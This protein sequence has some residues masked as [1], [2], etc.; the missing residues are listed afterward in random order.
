MLS[1]ASAISRVSR[2]PVVLVLHAG[3]NDLCLMR[4]SELLT[5]IRIDLDHIMVYFAE[6]I[7][8][9]SEVIPRVT[10]QG[11]RDAG[12]VECMRRTLNTRISRFVSSSGGLL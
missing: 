1:E 7:L 8:V 4:L 6:I 3:G 11:A 2:P 12:A 9:W 10:W 5:L